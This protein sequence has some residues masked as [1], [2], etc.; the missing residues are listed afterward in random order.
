MT[1]LDHLRKQFPSAKM[2]T[3]RRMIQSKRVLVNGV[4]AR[5]LKQTIEETD[6]IEVADRAKTAQTETTL[7]FPII[8]EDDDLLVIDKPPGLLTSTNEREKRPTALAMVR[9][10]LAASAPKA[11]VGLIHRLDRDA[12]GLLVFSK[13][14][15]AFRSL[16]S[17]FFEHSVLRTYHA[18]VK[19]VPSPS[20]GRI[21]SRLVELP[22]GKVKSTRRR[23]AGE[24]AISDYETVESIAGTS[25]VRVTLE[26]GKKHQIRVHLAERGCPIV[27]DPL[28]N[29][30]PRRGRLMLIATTLE[31]DHPRTDKRMR[32]ELPL[33]KDLEDLLC[34]FRK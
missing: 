22:D 7:P 21:E 32:F 5:T 8:H 19:G 2:V 13:N 9:D 14:S 27:N 11:R 31:F 15:A 26:T 3:L 17:Q 12:S 28:Y 24:R 18:I 16:K 1:L 10:Y 30:D 4:P 33:P 29:P 25:V 6:K 34:L 23:D 20:R